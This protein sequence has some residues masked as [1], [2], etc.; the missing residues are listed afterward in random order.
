MIVYGIEITS[1]QLQAAAER[2]Q[3]EPFEAHDIMHALEKAGVVRHAKAGAD[4][5]SLRATD[6]L[7]QRERLAGNITY[8]GPLWRW[9]GP[10]SAEAADRDDDALWRPVLEAV[11]RELPRSHNSFNRPGNAPGHGHDVPG[12][13]D[14]DNGDLSGKPCAWCLA[15]NTAKALLLKGQGP[16]AAAISS[17]SDRFMLDT[18]AGLTKKEPYQ[19]EKLEAK[20][21]ATSQADLDE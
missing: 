15:W 2:M 11:M 10:I 18:Q 14:S 19:P 13:W 9:I 6:R 7:I 3:A 12:I 5:V 17:A 21:L 16:E 1:E 20:R 4:P 8:E